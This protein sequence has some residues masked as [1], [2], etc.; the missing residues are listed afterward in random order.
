MEKR[1]NN[2]MNELTV[3]LNAVKKSLKTEQEK[4]EETIK[5]HEN[6]ISKLKETMNQNNKKYEDEISKLKEKLECL[7]KIFEAP[8][9]PFDKIDLP[10]LRKEA[11]LHIRE[12]ERRKKN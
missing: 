7:F 9:K 12:Y 1:F 4:H 3:Q 5:R 2:A 8:V 10:S 11:E 6:E